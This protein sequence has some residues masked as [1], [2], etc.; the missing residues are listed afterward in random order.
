MSRRLTGPSEQGGDSRLLTFMLLS[1][2]ILL[3]SQV[4]FSPRR[5]PDQAANGPAEV[6]ADE[7][8][9]AGDGVADGDGAAAADGDPAPPGDDTL[10]DD[11]LAD[12]AAAAIAPGP[13]AEPQ[14]LPLGSVEAGGPFRMLLTLDNRGAAVRRAEFSS[15]VFRDIDGRVGYLGELGLAAQAGGA[16]VSVVGP[17]TPAAT[18]GVAVGDVLTAIA[19]SEDAEGVSINSTADL[20]EYLATTTPGDEAVLTVLRGE[21]RLKLS[22]PLTRPPLAVIRPESENVRL[23]NPEMANPAFDVPSLLVSIDELNGR[24]QSNPTVAAANN[25]LQND[26]WEVVD[27]TDRSATMRLRLAGLGLEFEKRFELVEVPQD[28]RDNKDYRAY[29]FALDVRVKNLLAEP[30]SVAYQIAGPNGLPIEGWWYTNRIGRSETGAGIWMRRVGIRDVVARYDGSSLV[31]LQCSEI[32]EGKTAPIGQGAP[33]AYLGVDAQYFSVILMPENQDRSRAWFDVASAVLATP[34]LPE[35]GTYPT[36]NNASFTA[37]LKVVDLAAAGAAGDTL[38]DRFTVYAGPKRPDLLAQ[39]QPFGDPNYSPQY[40]IYYGY[41]GWVVRPMLW[42]LHTFYSFTQNY[43]IAIILL[44]VCVR[45]CMFPLSRKQAANMAKMQ[46]LKPEMDRIAEKYK[47]DIEKRS[48][49]QQEFYRKHNFNPMGGCLPMFVQLPIFIGLYRALAVDI[50]LRQAPLFGEAVR[51]CGNLGAPDAFYDWSWLMPQWFNNGQGVFA[52]GPYFNLLPLATIALFLLQQ[53]MFMPPPANEQAELQQKMM[54][55]M[56][57]FFG[58]MFFKVPSGLCLYFIASSL[59]GIAERKLLPK[60]TPPAGEG[61][62]KPSAS[63]KKPAPGDAP[64][65]PKPK[66]QGAGGGSGSAARKKKTGGRKKRSK[67]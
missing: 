51:F 4:F 59:W 28:Q 19:P 39:Y 6:Q 49:A 14:M 53:K 55:Y 61:F 41:F 45:G 65:K 18:A 20:R 66:P 46:E 23:H 12:G 47:D 37:T 29:H 32:A 15:S 27:A 35:K 16:R 31:Q 25:R 56:M 5:P 22:V 42:L 62:S 1:V 44:T 30:Q 9:R 64:G 11:T 36:Y 34:K 2:S 48:K 50:E 67:R 40:T 38:D 21:E 24:G 43:G 60:P 10:G 26:A 7:E 54:K 3:F 63:P 13:E 17:G 8:K 52:L 58:V 33:M 57:I